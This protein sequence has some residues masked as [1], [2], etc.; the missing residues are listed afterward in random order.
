M[1]D[2]VCWNYSTIKA[3]CLQNFV[4]C[5]NYPYPHFKVWSERIL[6]I[7]CKLETDDD[8]SINQLWNKVVHM[9]KRGKMK[10]AMLAVSSSPTMVYKCDRNQWQK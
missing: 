5:S 10:G 6:E 9:W 3:G 4:N 7:I 2:G 8:E 1:P